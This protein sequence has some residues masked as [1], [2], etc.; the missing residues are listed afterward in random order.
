MQINLPLKYLLLIFLFSFESVYA[1]DKISLKDPSVLFSISDKT[2]PIVD[3]DYVGWNVGF[4][5]A[6]TTINPTFI[7]GNENVSGSFTG[8]VNN[9]GIQYSGTVIPSP[10]SNQ[11][12]WTY[13]W[14]ALSQQHLDALGYGVECSL[15]RNSTTFLAASQAPV[16]LP[17]NQGWRWDTPDGSVEVKFTPA[18][19]K[20]YFEGTSQNKIRAMFFTAINA[21]ITPPPTTMTV[22]ISPKIALSAP[23]SQS[24]DNVDQTLWPQ[25]GLLDT[26]SPIDLS[27]LNKDAT[28]KKAP[29]GSH[30]F[31]TTNGDKLV[32]GDGTPAKFWGANLQ[33]S[34]LFKTADANIVLQAKRIAKLGFNL[35]RIH[36]H[37]SKWVNPNI[38]STVNNTLVL[39]PTAFHKLDLW[40]KSLKQ[41]GVY[42]WLDLHVGRAFTINDGIVNFN[43]FALG[44]KRAEAK[45]FNYYNTSIQARMQQFNEAFLNHVNLTYP[46]TDRL[47]YKNDP[48]I[49]GVLLSNENDLTTHYGNW[50]LGN[51]RPLHHALFVQEGKKFAGL[52]GLPLNKTL[53]TWVMGESK[54]YLNDVEHRFNQKMINHLNTLGVKSLIATTNSWGKMGVEGLPSITDG[55]IIDAHSYGQA[56]EFNRNPRY[57]P[58]FLSWIAGAQVSGK[59]LSVTEWN[60]GSFPSPDRFTVPLFTASLAS[61]QGWDAMMLYGY[62]QVELNGSTLVGSNWSSFNDP[63]MIGLMPA[64]ALLYRQEHVS[65]AIKSYE[66]KL[67]R[68]DFFFKK[69]DPTTSKTI[70]TLLETSR[71]TVGM[72]STDTPEL[73]WLKSKAV[74]ATPVGANSDFIPAGQTNFVESDT[75]ELKRDWDTGVHT[76][77]TTRSQIA[78]GWIGGKSIDLG[79]VSFNVTTKKAVVAVQSLENNPIITSKNIFITAMARCQ[80]GTGNTL[81]FLCEPL[82][83][84][85]TLKAPPGLRVFSVTNTGASV[86]SV[87]NSYTYNGTDGTY[88]VDLQNAAGH[89]LIL[90]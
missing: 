31:I 17:G 27:F 57:N 62:S 26:A 25:S 40:I 7:V 14:G 58:G 12:D 75:K 9:L 16:L 64:A 42:V 78:S 51:K 35:I 63:A 68:N 50:L 38:F 55:S 36:H 10:I 4:K 47:A 74:T 59:P 61:L 83:G 90:K 76:I 23:V 20:I 1:F 85:I 24:Y 71:L 6:G 19:A 67:G 72:P 66:L 87:A 84:T 70:R 34:A 45:G 73:P 54:L 30:G 53:A 44:Q 49:V 43:D 2:V 80:P 21:G 56:E 32:F 33:A 86:L 22:T 48:A 11:I 46:V 18:L 41:E 5:W 88:T 39:S 60:M 65:P 79:D 52:Y 69:T 81:P 15:N 37:D 13:N 82:A 77:N 8:Q 89:W 29:A 28:G 3:C